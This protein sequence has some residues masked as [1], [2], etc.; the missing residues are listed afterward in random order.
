MCCL[1]KEVNMATLKEI[2]DE[3]TMLQHQVNTY[4]DYAS[5]ADTDDGYPSKS[6]MEKRIDQ[7]KSHLEVRAE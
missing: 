2:V 4:D 6:E 7:L 5:T 1:K 3:I